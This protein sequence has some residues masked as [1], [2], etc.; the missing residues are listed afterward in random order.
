MKLFP[1]VVAQIIDY[2]LHVSVSIRNYF[3]SV[4]WCFFCDLRSTP[5]AFYDYH[6]FSFPQAPKGPLIAWLKVAC[7]IL[8]SSKRLHQKSFG[9][10]CCR[11]DQRGQENGHHRRRDPEDQLHSLSSHLLA[12]F[13]LLQDFCNLR[14]CAACLF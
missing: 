2:F 13:H 9:H 1:A 11:D 8:I 4:F 3:D 6:C 10:D 14:E 5:I 12:L 7:D